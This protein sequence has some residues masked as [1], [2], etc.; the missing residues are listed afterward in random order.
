[1]FISITGAAGRTCE[2]GS[3]TQ[4]NLAANL[5]IEVKVR[6]T[7]RAAFADKLAALGFRLLTPETL[8]H[9]TLLDTPDGLLRQRRQLLRIRRYGEKWVLT[10]KADA[11]ISAAS[12]H[13]VR[14][15]TETEVEDGGALATIFDQLGYRPVFL[16]E[17]LRTEWTDDRGHVVIDA[18]PIGDFAELE[19]DHGW[20]DTT[21][22]Q[23]GIPPSEYLT[24]SYARLFLDWKNATRHSAMNMTFTEIQT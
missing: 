10:H 23:L 16:Y 4:E 17:K 7:D 8:E 5:E 24:A 21:A 3:M 6:L 14:V 11:G 9:N 12:A 22:A 2:T 19:G 15:E 18:T 13:K 1:M 20:I